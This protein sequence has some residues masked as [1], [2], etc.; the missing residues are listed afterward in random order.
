MSYPLNNLPLLFVALI[1]GTLMMIEGVVIVRSQRQVIPIP[2]RIL[3]FI[4]TG[5]VGREKISQRFTSN[6]TPEN[7]R[8]Y[9]YF[10]LVFGTAL[11]LSASFI[12][13]RQSR[14]S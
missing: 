12:C 11:L 2:T 5:L 1:F 9:A 14:S 13:I 3:V 7:L 10:D 8:T 4:G 6:N